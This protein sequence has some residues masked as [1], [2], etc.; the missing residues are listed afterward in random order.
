[1]LRSKQSFDLQPATQ[2]RW[3]Q[4]CLVPEV[5][6]ISAERNPKTQR[7]SMKKGAIPQGGEIHYEH[8]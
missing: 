4:A 3:T 7:L 6:I 1:M 5:M 8:N 2:T